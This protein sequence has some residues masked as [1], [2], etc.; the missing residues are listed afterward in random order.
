MFQL[1]MSCL[2]HGMSSAAEF[3]HGQSLSDLQFC[4]WCEKGQILHPEQGEPCLNLLFQPVL[5]LQKTLFPW[6]GGTAKGPDFGTKQSQAP[7]HHSIFASCDT[8]VSSPTSSL[9]FKQHLMVK[10]KAMEVL[11]HPPGKTGFIIT[12][13]SGEVVLE[14]NKPDYHC[15]E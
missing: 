6:M 8:F 3:W 15:L 2:C 11:S 12:L 13:S 14:W 7:V 1:E 5:F 4:F 9:T 10:T